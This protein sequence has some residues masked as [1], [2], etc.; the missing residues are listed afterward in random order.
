M[1][2]AQVH[3][4]GDV[5]VHNGVADEIGARIKEKAM[6]NEGSRLEIIECRPVVEEIGRPLLHNSAV[7]LFSATLR[8]GL[9][10]I[11]SIEE[12]SGV[13]EMNRTATL[14]LT[15]QEC[16]DEVPNYPVYHDGEFD[17]ELTVELELL[18][19]REEGVV[20]RLEVLM[21]Q[22]EQRLERI[23]ASDAL[24]H[25]RAREATGRAQ[26]IAAAPAVPLYGGA[27][28]SYAQP[29]SPASPY[30][31]V[32]CAPRCTQ[33]AAAVHAAQVPPNVARVDLA[34]HGGEHVAV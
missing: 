16:G 18:N 31:S 5:E 7:M 11:L 13:G 28:S 22:L 27:G 24:S 19:Y 34:Q 3:A 32:A 2:P 26:A 23:L 4:A 25:P 9:A 15:G 30:M 1:A 14:I 29:V 10:G 21:R 17:L 20:E 33:P 8:D 12:Q 6:K